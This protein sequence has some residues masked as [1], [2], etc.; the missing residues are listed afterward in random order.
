MNK[1]AAA[2]VKKAAEA[3]QTAAAR[4]R[5]DQQRTVTWPEPGK[6]SLTVPDRGTAEAAPGS[7]PVTAT[8]PAKGKRPLRH[9]RGS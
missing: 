6:A 4:A 5:H 3:D 2:E 8:S 1:K 9:R 7:L